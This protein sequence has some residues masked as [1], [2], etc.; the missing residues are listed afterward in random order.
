MTRCP[1]LSSLHCWFPQS[2]PFNT[3]ASRP[4]NPA[5]ADGSTLFDGKNLDHWDRRQAPRP[6]KI[7]DGAVITINKKDP[8]AV[9]S[10]LTTEESYKDFELRA[11]FWVQQRTPTAAFSS[12]AS[13]AKI[14]AKICY[15]FNIFDQRPDPSYGTGSIVYIGEVDPMPKASRQMEHDGN[16]RQRPASH[17]SRSTAR[18]PPTCTTACSTRATYAAVR[19]RR[20]KF[21]KVEVKP[22]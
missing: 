5:A 18:R 22:L 9:A 3:P 16:Q 1:A 21:R 12:A 15:E 6:F 10:Y 19:L 11:E 20:I 7:E 2:P 17:L 4:A 13:R 8:K 14:G